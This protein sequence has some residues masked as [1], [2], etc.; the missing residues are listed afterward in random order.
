[1]KL[2]IYASLGTAV[3]ALSSTYTTV[4]NTAPTNID[5]TDIKTSSDSVA[6]ANGRVDANVLTLLDGL[7]TATLQSCDLTDNINRPGLA[8][9]GISNLVEDLNFDYAMGLILEADYDR[10]VAGLKACATANAGVQSEVD[11]LD[12]MKAD[13]VS[14]ANKPG[15][16]FAQIAT[17]LTN[18]SSLGAAQLSA[19]EF[20]PAM[21]KSYYKNMQVWSASL[22]SVRYPISGVTG[23]FAF[24]GTT[25]ANIDTVTTTF[26]D[27]AAF[28]S[29]L[30]KQLRLKA[31]G[32]TNTFDQVHTDRVALAGEWFVDAAV[33]QAQKDEFTNMID[34]RKTAF[35]T[36]SGYFNTAE[37]AYNDKSQFSALYETILTDN[38]SK[39]SSGDA[40][41]SYDSVSS[42]LSATAFQDVDTWLIGMDGS[43]SCKTEMNDVVKYSENF[44]V[45]MTLSQKL[46]NLYMLH[47]FRYIDNTQM[48][49]E[50]DAFDACI[51]DNTNS[52]T[53]TERTDY[54]AALRT[55]ETALSQL[56]TAKIDIDFSLQ[57]AYTNDDTSTS[58]TQQKITLSATEDNSWYVA[59]LV[60]VADLASVY[61]AFPTAGTFDSASL[62]SALSNFNTQT[63]LENEMAKQL[64][65]YAVASV[66]NAT[67]STWVAQ[68]YDNR[69]TLATVFGHTGATA[70]TFSNSL[71]SL[72][73]NIDSLKST[74]DTS[75]AAYEIVVA[76]ITPMSLSS[77]FI[78]VHAANSAKFTGTDDAQVAAAASYASVVVAIAAA[79]PTVDHVSAYST[80]D[81][82]TCQDRVNLRFGID[83]TVTYYGL[84]DY[85]YLYAF[86]YIREEDLDL[87]ISAYSDCLN[88]VASSSSSASTLI[89]NLSTAKAAIVQYTQGKIDLDWTIYTNSVNPTSPS[90]ARVTFTTDEAKSVYKGLRMSFAAVAALTAY[91]DLST[92]TQTNIATNSALAQTLTDINALNTNDPNFSTFADY[93]YY[94]TR[95]QRE[96]ATDKSNDY[97]S[98]F[99][100]QASEIADAL[101]LTGSDKTS[102]VAMAAQSKTLIDTWVETTRSMESNYG[103]GSQVGFGLA[104]VLALVSKML[105]E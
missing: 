24:A 66:L 79:A 33:T 29:Y 28:E 105:L 32:M 104:V 48:D 45:E 41:T 63:L 25:W 95:E 35:D 38:S 69:A 71:S 70:T 55:A 2:P 85:L 6:T 19:T 15:F 21:Q 73:T 99:F 10:A 86:K 52:L 67:D 77:D 64:R 65:D 31:L 11:T 87:A 23:V 27:L 58:D 101:A 44:G 90:G 80:A 88:N 102:Y 98:H 75:K 94:L 97:E 83:F 12:L 49:L 78:S 3:S 40:K 72:K 22:M 50:L 13:I 96:Y 74:Y 14:Y 20:T 84:A 54:K 57:T 26:A 68:I 30:N 100:N 47:A 53:A 76:N 93:G 39:F 17:D 46:H 60:K 42:A 51:D 103:S 5:N 36:L 16:N 82:T 92:T 9:N 8:Q 1:M 4:S 61:A 56:T 34:N 18:P 43:T 59:D 37:S 62:P 7:T 81:M 91:N 89:T